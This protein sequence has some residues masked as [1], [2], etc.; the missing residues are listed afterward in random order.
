LGIDDATGFDSF[1]CIYSD[2]SEAEY[3]ADT[4]ENFDTTEYQVYV[5]TGY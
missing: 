5:I 2:D 3:E 4:G 1:D